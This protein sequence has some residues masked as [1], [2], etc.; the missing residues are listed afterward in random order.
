[1]NIEFIQNNK[2]L[3][4]ENAWL[5]GFT[6]SEG[7]FTISIIKRSNT[8]NQ[9]QVRYILSQKEELKLM[10]KIAEMLNGKITYI[11]SYNGYNMTVNL[12]KLNKIISYINKYPLKTK[13]NINYLTWLKV[14]KLII[15]KEHFN[16]NGLKKIKNLINKI[17]KD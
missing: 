5:S 15:N 12:S 3:T 11:K 16:D 9:V 10:T 13:K 14:Y 1:M 17:N 8:Y 7:C 2:I 6:D 4:L